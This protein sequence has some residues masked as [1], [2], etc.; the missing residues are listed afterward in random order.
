MSNADADRTANKAGGN[1]VR[2]GRISGA[3]GIRGEVRIASFTDA[4]EGIAAYGALTDG[5]GR[6]FEIASLRP[7]KGMAVVAAFAG[8]T[9]R[10]AAEALKGVDLYIERDKLPE[11]DEEEWYHA[12]LI[13][14]D[15]VSAEG[16]AIGEVV[17]VQD[18]GAGDLLEIRVPGERQTMLIPFTKA[19]VPV[20]DV[21]ARRLVIVPLE[22]V[23]DDDD[24]AE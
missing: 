12:D 3:H 15:A 18:F 14:L 1:L 22:D 17:A 16:E 8:V 6:R 11:P 9:D 24:D 19:C 23:G 13:G 20:V 5:Q 21:K 2:L 4:P 10:N 7:H